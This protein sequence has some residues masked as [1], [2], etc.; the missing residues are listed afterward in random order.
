MY[1]NHLA[2]ELKGTAIK[3][4]AAHPGWVKTDLGGPEAPMEI[5]DGA[6]TSVWLATL[7]EK[8]PSGGFF[9]MMVHMRW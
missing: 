9:H 2:H 4:N 1:T 7:D 3:V 5:V 6:K 8:G